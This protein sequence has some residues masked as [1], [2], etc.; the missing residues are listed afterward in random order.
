MTV[1]LYCFG[2]GTGGKSTKK[3]KSESTILNKKLI[4]KSKPPTP[5]AIIAIEIVDPNENKTSKNSKRTIESS[6]GYG[7]HGS[8]SSPKYEVYKYSQHDIPPYRGPSRNLFSGST[9]THNF[10]IQKSI[11]YNLQPPS[12]HYTQPQNLNQFY[13]PGTTLFS[14]VNN[15]GHVGGLSSHLPQQNQGHDPHVPVIILRVLPSQ[16]ADPSAVLHPNLPQSHPYAAAINSIDI[17]SLLSKYVQNL[18]VNQNRYQQQ[19]QEQ[20]Y[21]Y[22]YQEP[23]HQQVQYQQP[24]NYQYEQQQEYQY[25]QPEENYQYGGQYEQE[26]YQGHNSHSDGL[27]THENYPKDTHTRV[28][29][30]TDKNKAG[31]SS[32]HEV[33]TPHLRTETKTIK[34]E[35]P[36]G[37]FS[38]VEVQTPHMQYSYGNQG[39]SS[40][41]QD[42]Y[43][44]PEE[45]PHQPTDYYYHSENSK[46]PPATLYQYYQ[47]EETHSKEETPEKVAPVNQHAN[48]KR[49]KKR[50]SV[51]RAKKVVE[52]KGITLDPIKA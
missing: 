5:P 29:F 50:N 46:Q 48:Q 28:I 22:Q 49:S 10:D 40:S 51:I 23:Q 15:Q 38:G 7:Y 16:L 9:R 11:S 20:D 1:L 41:N 25:E 6:L 37:A 36:P 18:L 3:N 39:A 33:E 8:R 34:V 31:I 24:Q 44:S 21:D 43:Y 17:Q 35:V 42:Y 30:R 32:E 27:L 13:Q 47:P 26:S 52:P 4:N 12:T 19:Q 45:T 14:T 2:T